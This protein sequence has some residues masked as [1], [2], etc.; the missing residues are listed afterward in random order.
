M[1]D[2]RYCQYTF[3]TDVIHR[4]MLLLLM[5][6]MLR[7]ELCAGP[8]GARRIHMPA[9]TVTCCWKYFLIL[10]YSRNILDVQ[11]GTCHCVVHILGRQR[12]D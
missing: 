2:D 11:L 4:P 6:L 8:T 1:S 7:H 9:V 3:V 12:T 10:M 5:W